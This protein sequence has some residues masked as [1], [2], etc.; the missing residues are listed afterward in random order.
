MIGF[1]ETNAPP[2]EPRLVTRALVDQVFGAD[3]WLA[4]HLKL[5]DRPPQTL[6]SQRIASAMEGDAPL[7]F[8]A[9]TG[10][11]K[12]LAYLIPGIIQA[13]TQGRP[14]IVSTHTI[15][16]QEQI[17]KKDLPL[18]RELFQAVP[19]LR[20]LAD[21]KTVLFVGR[22][23]Y[24]CTTRLVR[25]IQDKVDLFGGPEQNMLENLAGWA[26]ET[27]TGL[28]Q[29]FPPPAPSFDLWSAVNADSSVCNSRNCQPDNC[30]YQAARKR[31][32]SAQVIIVN[33]SLLFALLNAQGN[34]GK[35]RGVLLPNDFVVLDEAHTISAV[36]TEHFGLSLSSFGLERLLKRLHNPE[37]KKGL[38]TRMV[39]RRDLQVVEG[40]LEK[41]TVFFA[42]IARRFLQR[43]EVC[44]LTRPNWTDPILQEPLRHLIQILAEQVNRVD[45]GPA[46]DELNDHKNRVESYYHGL[47]QTI[48]LAEPEHVHWVERTGKKK[49]ITTIRTA[50]IDIAPL[51]R[52]TLFQRKTSVILTS[53]TLAPGTSLIP[54]ARSVGADQAETGQ[55]ASPFDYE[56]HTTTYIARDLSPPQR[57][58]ARLAVHEL[59]DYISFFVHRVAGGSLVLFTSYQDLRQV[60][61]LLEDDFQ[62]AG[63]PFFRQTGTVGRSALTKA[64]QQAGNGVLFGTDSFWTGVDIPGPALSQ[65]IL[66]RLPFENPSHPIVAAKMEW[67]QSQGKSSFGDYSLPQAILKFRQGIGRLIRTKTDTGNLVLL[68]SRLTSRPYG[69]HFLDAL[70]PSPQIMVDR[71]NREDRVPHTRE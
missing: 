62:A 48:S 68:D 12:S 30:P 24:L 49:S 32:R 16:L 53:A 39:G 55:V 37:K 1:E 8:E 71:Q 52:S 46:R 51:L 58:N 43:S 23:N 6:M 57:D 5:E 41:S 3:G 66:T 54:F 9:G 10:C 38:L 7:L 21:F 65:V 59:A 18:C 14:L 20:H 22:G 13:V 67:L 69:K 27:K 29:D 44:R 36:A 50:P 15:A 19:E 2:E 17:E 40:L 31:L 70:P 61:D 56:R 42:D 60:G 45:E 4:Q 11:G 33:H 64:F 63:R 35:G 28:I 47:N 25:A 34:P 26:Q